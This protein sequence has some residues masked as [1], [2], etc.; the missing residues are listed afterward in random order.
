MAELFRLVQSGV[1]LASNLGT[2]I[3]VHVNVDGARRLLGKSLAV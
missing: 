3:N 2:P 1:S